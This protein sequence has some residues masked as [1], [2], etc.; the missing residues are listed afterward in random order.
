MAEATRPD[1]IIRT[2]FSME[3]V[4]VPIC[5]KMKGN[6]YP[7][8]WARSDGYMHFQGSTILLSMKVWAQLQ[9]IHEHPRSNSKW[10]SRD[11]F[12]PGIMIWLP[13]ESNTSSHVA[14]W[15]ACRSSV[16]AN[17]CEKIFFCF[18]IRSFTFHNSIGLFT[19]PLGGVTTVDKTAD[20]P[21]NRFECDY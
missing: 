16:V 18:I 21:L 13:G 9:D 2:A 8:A 10:H 4:P 19:T 7:G 15:C 20:L 3:C 17:D 5:A 11:R 14:R 6:W 1:L 12:C